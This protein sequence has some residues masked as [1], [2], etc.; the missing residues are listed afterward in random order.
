MH[1]VGLGGDSLRLD[2]N[3]MGISRG[4]LIAVW[5]GMSLYSAGVVWLCQA[6]N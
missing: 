2:S 4:G 1:R 3:G 5:G 6:A